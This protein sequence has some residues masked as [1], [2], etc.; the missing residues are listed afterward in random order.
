M[1]SMPNAEV[2]SVDSKSPSTHQAKSAEQASKIEQGAAPREES[3]LTLRGTSHGL[4]VW[5]AQNAP[6]AKELAEL[7]KEQLNQSPDF[8]SGGDAIVHFADKPPKG[9]ISAL[10]SCAE[11]FSLRIV[12]VRTDSLEE[13][14][15]GKSSAA[16]RLS[17]RKAKKSAPA[18]PGQAGYPLPATRYAPAYQEAVEQAK[19]STAPMMIPGPVRSGTCFEAPGHL[20][21]VGDVN[22]GAEIRAEGNIVVL[23]SLRGIAHAG[24]QGEAA[25]I[26]ALKLAP[27]QLRIGSLIAR[28]GDSDNP[29]SGAEI[30]YA[31]DNMIVVDEYQGRLPHT[32]ANSI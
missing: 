16:P 30:A 28:A 19:A 25:F 4:E 6:E 8:F 26:L 23:G 18:T 1:S 12:A 13:S 31:A 7:L 24:N 10:E 21:V 11:E 5:I 3:A 22:P 29:A 27:Q 15:G 32:I 2:A 17:E 14:E 20:V 9:A